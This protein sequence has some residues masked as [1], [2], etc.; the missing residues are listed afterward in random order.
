MLTGLGPHEGSVLRVDTDGKLVLVTGA[1][2]HG[3]G[4]ATALA[5]IVADELGIRPT[6]VS[7][8]HGD[9]DAIS[10]G[11]GTYASRNAVVA[12]GAAQAAARRV[13]D[14]ALALAA[15][16]LETSPEDL[17]LVDGGVQV[18]GVPSAAAHA[19]PARRRRRA[20]P[21]HAR[22]ARAWAGEHRSISWPH[23]PPSPAGCT[24]PWSRSTATRF[25]VRIL[26]Y[27]AVSDA[28]PLINP[29]IVQGQIVGGVAQGLGGALYEEL[30][31]D[32]N[33]QLV[34]SVAARLLHADRAP[35]ARGARRPP[36]D[37]V[38]A[39]SARHQGPGGRRRAGAT[40]GDRQR[41]RGCAR[42]PRGA[43]GCHA[44]RTAIATLL[45][46]VGYWRSE[47]SVR[48]P[49]RDL[50][51]PPPTCDL[52]SLIAYHCPHVT[53]DVGELDPPPRLLMG[54]GPSNPEPRVLRALATPLVGQFD[55]AFTRVMDD[56]A[57]L[58][59][60]VFDTANV[61]SFPVS[62]ASRAGIEAVLASLIEAGDR[63]VV[64]NF[65]RFGDLLVE[66]ARRYGADVESIDVAW[67]EAVDPTLVEQS[68]RRQ[69]AA[70]VAL[71]HADTST[72]ILQPL[73]DIARIARDAGALVVVDTVLSLGGCELRVDDWQ[74]DAAIGGLQK[75]LGGPPGIAPLT[76][77]E[78]V[79]ARLA[80]RRTPP[81]TN[82]LDLLQLQAYWSP[83]RLNHHTA[84]TS[85]VYALREAL[86]L[87]DAEGLEARWARHRRQ[88]T[89]SPPGCGRWDS[90]SLATRRTRHP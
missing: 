30:A 20:R 53:L 21:A 33:G 77:N 27:V 17:E 25:E 64:A 14:K 55:P 47:T 60:R 22:R 19:R 24:W 39:E 5:Q 66:L 38:A 16:Q 65:G 13:R 3:Q 88:E 79:D 46:E 12:G 28:G 32:E 6:D 42:P 59:R 44:A 29:M 41:G 7:V 1:S 31:Y 89:R 40:A 82:Y 63:V 10:Y 57:A 48:I 49:L 80:R 26:D 52:R 76:Y 78:R 54:S 50:R 68:L 4:T 62:G 23:A 34:A 45:S 56:V 37:A 9:T 8:R 86:R 67:G 90:R 51:P 43:R 2:P 85:M 58:E 61:H 84:P 18:R 69:P 81:R 11:V 83:A 75:C 35:G 87:V 70:I 36:A 71:V 73:P 72:G 74:L 15:R